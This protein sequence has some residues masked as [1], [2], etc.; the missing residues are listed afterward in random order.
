MRQNRINLS[1]RP[2]TNRRLF[3]L[4]IV[5][6]V[7]LCAGCGFWISQARAR[8]LI[9]ISGLQVQMASR[10]AEV[11]R[12]KREDEERRKQEAK[13]FLTEQDSYHLAAARLLIMRK[14]FAWDKM[15]G[16]LERFVP[17][18]ARVVTIKVN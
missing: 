2:F 10:K 14:S 6:V 18:S 1:S 4:G 9:R 5:C 17:K 7:C 16:D 8:A 13:I 3:W 12:V 15:V 11:E